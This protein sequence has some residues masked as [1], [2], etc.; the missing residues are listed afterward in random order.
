[1]VARTLATG[2][3][4]QKEMKTFDTAS[5]KTA[6][7]SFAAMMFLTISGCN[8]SSNDSTATPPPT[9]S[10][11]DP[12]TVKSTGPIDGAAGTPTNTKVIA[13]FSLPMDPFTVDTVSFTIGA[14]GE[15]AVTGSVEVTADGDAATYIATGG[16]GPDTTYTATLSTLVES[17][18]GVAMESDHVWSFTT[19]ETADNTAPVIDST[20]PADAEIDVPLNRSISA[21]FNETM[22][23][24]TIGT[25]SFTLHGPDS[26]QITGTVS[27]LGTTATFDPN[28]L[29]QANTDYIAVISTDASDLS[30]NS[31]AAEKSWSFTT[32]ATEAA[33]PALVSLGTA[34]NYVILA[35][36]GISTTG[37]TSIVGHIAVS[38]A[39]ETFITG[40]SQSRDAS[41]EFST[42]SIVDGRI[43]AADMAAPTPSKLTTAI[44]DMEIAYN[45]AAGRTT[46][47]HTELGAGDVSGMT[48]E[49]GLY[50]W[51]TGLLIASDVT[52]SGGSND[53]WIF[54][55]AE[56]LTVEN[57]IQVTL[58]GGALPK[59]IFWQV[60]GAVTLGTTSDFKGIL[61][62]KTRIAVNNGAA[63]NGRAFAQTAVTLDAN[64]VTQPAD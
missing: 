59:N 3:S 17:A 60:A 44:G 43:Y 61:L 45:D 52:L 53:V 62:S 19:G 39:A 18:D 50:K 5:F 35:K 10:T 29:L 23:S 42:S 6:A 30:G 51:G 1:M 49:P 54:Q 13:T 7:L 24:T 14:D 12:P 41:D 4:E 32:S 36:S 27:Y 2:S 47:D 55:I 48:L 56:D 31:M 16:F 22:D 33:G 21:V 37:T 40:F 64:A 8:S 26:A 57:G 15:A 38:P 28:E 9:G 25:T 20:K 58:A 46:P 11:G 63:I 34:G